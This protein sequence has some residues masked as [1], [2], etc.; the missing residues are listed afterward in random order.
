ME[1][2]LNLDTLVQ[3]NLSDNCVLEYFGTLYEIAYQFRCTGEEILR[4]NGFRSRAWVESLFAVA[5]RNRCFASTH[6][7]N[8]LPFE[9]IRPLITPEIVAH[10]C[11]ANDLLETTFYEY[12]LFQQQQMLNNLPQTKASAQALKQIHT[13]RRKFATEKTVFLKLAYGPKPTSQVVNIYNDFSTSKKNKLRQDVLLAL[14]LMPVVFQIYP[15]EDNTA[16]M[17]R[18]QKLCRKHI[19]LFTICSDSEEL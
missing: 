9:A 18:V 6:N 15:R 8:G 2:D 13:V 16:D 17:A 4:H 11:L 3:S 10:I 1:L 14:E 5:A 12:L 7:P 19:R